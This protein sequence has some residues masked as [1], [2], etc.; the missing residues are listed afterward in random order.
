MSSPRSFANLSIK[1]NQTAGIMITTALAL[2]LACVGFFVFDYVSIRKGLTEELTTLSRIVAYNARAAVEFEDTD[3][4]GETLAS[5][6]E[7]PQII[8]AAI[9]AQQD[10]I[11]ATYNREGAQTAPFPGV[12]DDMASGA[13]YHIQWND[14]EIDG[15]RVGS[16]YLRA[17]TSKVKRRQQQYLMIALAVLLVS[18]ASGFLISAQLGRIIVSPITELEQAVQKIGDGD[19]GL[20]AIKHGDDELGH[21]VDGF[22][23][24]VGEI[25]KREQQVAEMAL[26][27]ELNPAPVLKMDKKGN[28]QLANK[29]ARAIFGED[30]LV[31]DSWYKICPPEDY[32]ALAEAVD[33]SE[34]G[35][36]IDQQESTIGD[37]TLLLTFQVAPN[38]EFVNVYGADATDLRRTATELEKAREKAET[39]NR[40]KSEFLANMSHELRTPLNAVLG[41]SETLQLGVYGAMN[42]K[43]EKAL[44]QIQSSGRHLLDLINDVLDLSKIEANRFELELGTVDVNDLCKASVEFVAEEARR[45]R[46]NLSLN[47]DESIGSICADERRMKQVLVNLLHNAVKFTRGDGLVSLEVEAMEQVKAVSFTISDT[48]I[49]IAQDRLELLFKPFSQAD[50]S[51]A[52][53]FGGTGLGLSLVYSLVNLH[54]GS[55]SVETEEGKGSR[56][57]VTVPWHPMTPQEK[58]AKVVQ[59]DSIAGAAGEYAKVLKKALIVE[60]SSITSDQLTRYLAE[61]G[62]ESVVHTV[63]RGAVDRVKEEKPGLVLLDLRLPDVSGWAVLDQ[64]KQD[65]ETKNIPVVIIS[66]YDDRAMGLERGAVDYFIKPVTPERLEESLKLAS[67]GAMQK[68]SR[69]E[70]PEGEEEP[71]SADGKNVLL[72]ED[73][74]ANIGPTS[75]FLE[76]QG[77]AVTVARN[78][79]EAVHSAKISKPDIILMDIQMP[80][81]DGLEA[82]RRIRGHLKLKTPIIALTALAMPGDR[83]RCIEAGVN[84]YMSKPVSFRSLSDS[85][86]RLLS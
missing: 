43:Q 20:R 45:K 24:M 58:P 23:E 79:I 22:N 40:F 16:V 49:G 85:M 32:D 31:G 63:G 52:R 70:L 3:A 64:L 60:D 51:L 81:M 56:F 11:F 13:N 15:D 44:M 2:L 61:V 74:E 47:V 84:E 18:S 6:Q 80:E 77:Y 42:E 41:L 21:L 39:A 27:A 26:F 78:G 65:A 14:I 57:T 35:P 5:L 82:T 33:A 54:N 37:Q 29:A 86:E 28:I 7:H 46:I 59:P 17:D 4:A 50:A 68:T 69:V 53:E 72:V 66:M 73:N 10:G 30:D 67:L 1:H 8:A 12:P 9:Y 76:A 55:V 19:Y 48:G 62:M 38:G 34:S 75:D 25:E 83:E 36:G 71:A